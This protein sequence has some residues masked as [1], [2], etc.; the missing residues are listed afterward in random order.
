M[1][2]KSGHRF[3]QKI[4]LKQKLEPS[5]DSTKNDSALGP[6]PHEA[7]GRVTSAQPPTAAEE[8]TSPEVA[9]GQQA[10][11]KDCGPDGRRPPLGFRPTREAQSHGSKP[12]ADE[13][14]GFSSINTGDAS[15]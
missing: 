6:C 14:A 1:I 2:P 3:S 8:R 15:K 10:G 11:M 7:A 9:E 4:M 5:S 13:P 12:A